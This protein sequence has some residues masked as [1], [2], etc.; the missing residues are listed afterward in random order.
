MHRF[1][2][3]WTLKHIW[4]LCRLSWNPSLCIYFTGSHCS[5]FLPVFSSCFLFQSFLLILFPFLMWLDPLGI[6]CNMLFLLAFITSVLPVILWFFKHCHFFLSWSVSCQIWNQFHPGPWG[7]Q[8]YLIKVSYF[9]VKV[10][11][12]PACLTI[13]VMSIDWINIYINTNSWTSGIIPC[14]HTTFVSL[15][16]GW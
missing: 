8:Y 7:S 13:N 12:S 14:F 15:A 3:D 10:L 2:R 5:L 6:L 1:L 11:W 16:A 4:T 9:H